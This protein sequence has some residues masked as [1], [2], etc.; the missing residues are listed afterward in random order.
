MSGVGDLALLTFALSALA[1]SMA[2]AAAWGPVQRFAVR[3]SP[4]SGALVLAAFGTLPVAGA[5]VITAA[6]F[7]PSLIGLDHCI[8]H[9][10]SHAHFCFNHG[11]N[12][13][14]LATV[15]AAAVAVAIAALVVRAIHVAVR[16]A[17]VASRLDG[18]LIDSGGHAVLA[19][20]RPVALTVG[21]VRPRVVVS[22]ALVR[23]DRREP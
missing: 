17:R 5:I 4:A 7:V 9:D 19:C 20:D 14:V 16:S 22:S 11:A 15:L 8:T 1:L 21:L 18:W 6:C 12:G 3:L 23:E 13:G 2:S 10:D